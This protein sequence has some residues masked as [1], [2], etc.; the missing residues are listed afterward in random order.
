MRYHVA[1]IVGY[2]AA[3]AAWRNISAASWTRCQWFAKIWYWFVLCNLSSCL[4][5]GWRFLNLFLRG[6]V[7]IPRSLCCHSHDSAFDKNKE[8]YLRVRPDPV[9]AV[10]PGEQEMKNENSG[11]SGMGVWVC[12]CG[13]PHTD[14]RLP[15]GEAVLLICSYNNKE[16]LLNKEWARSLW[17][18]FLAGAVRSFSVVSGNVQVTSQVFG[19]SRLVKFSMLGLCFAI[20]N[21]TKQSKSF[22]TPSAKYFET[23]P[24]YRACFCNLS[25][26]N[27]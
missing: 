14:P 11:N 6:R 13:W 26:F 5:L 16:F 17:T 22:M 1:S 12:G 8:L 23:C 19:W 10:F 27:L 2:T 15:S 25:Y 7:K 4:M 3:R 24:S 9:W 21:K 18:V 20:E